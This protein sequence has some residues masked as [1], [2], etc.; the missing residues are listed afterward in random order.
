MPACR[1]EEKITLGHRQHIR[2]F[3]PQQNTVSLDLIRLWVDLDVWHG[4]HQHMRYRP[5]VNSRRNIITVHDLNHVYAKKGLSLWWQNM[6]LT[7]HLRRA[8]QLVAISQFVADDIRKHLPWA[9]P[10]TVIHNG[11][12]D[13]TLSG[14]SGINISA[15]SIGAIGH[16]GYFRPAAQTL[17]D[18]TLNWFAELQAQR[19][20]A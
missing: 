3:T 10:A 17:W 12:A 16:M 19:Q 2:R 8:H 13:L 9:P 5:P 4:L 7:R 14:A 6:R 11:V 20:A 18:E 15:A 1:S